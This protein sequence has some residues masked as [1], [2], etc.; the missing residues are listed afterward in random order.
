VAS[1]A[2]AGTALLEATREQGQEGVVAKRLQSIYLPGRRDQELAQD[3]AR[4]A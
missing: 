2:G 4:P 3:Q 1:F